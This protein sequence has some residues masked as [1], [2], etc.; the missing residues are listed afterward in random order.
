L[1]KPKTGARFELNFSM[2]LTERTERTDR[3]IKRE[4][5]CDRKRQIEGRP[6][7]CRQTRKEIQME[8]K[9]T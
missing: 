2:T 1:I 3:I 4:R 8:R 9:K 6:D 7:R 5:H